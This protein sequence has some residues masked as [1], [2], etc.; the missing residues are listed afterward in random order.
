ML[1][2]PDDIEE[3]LA[4]FPALLPSFQAGLRSIMFIPLI[5]K[6]QFIGAFSLRSLKPK[7]YTDENMRVAE[8][9]ANQVAGAIANAQLYAERIQAEKERAAIQE[10][11]RQSQKV[12]AIGRLAGGIAHDFNNLLT[13]I[14]G[15]SQLSLMEI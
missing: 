12:E 15:N 14:K 9:I 6:D 2:Q 8:G 10:Q 11:L 4:R 7:A 13:I 1:I 3:C 5:S